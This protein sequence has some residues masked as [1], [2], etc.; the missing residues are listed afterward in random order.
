MS[1]FPPPW[2]Q[3]LGPLGPFLAGVGSILVALRTGVVQRLLALAQARQAN[4]ATEGARLDLNEKM[5]QRI[6]ALSEEVTRLRGEVRELKEFVRN[7][8]DSAPRLGVSVTERGVLYVE[9]GPVLL[10]VDDDATVCIYVKMALEEQNYTVCTATNVADALAA[11]G[12]QMPAVAIL[13]LYLGAETCLPIVEA[14][15]AAVTPRPTQIIL[16]TGAN[17]AAARA[18]V[19]QIDP[20]ALLVKGSDDI[21]RLQSTVKTALAK[22]EASAIA[23]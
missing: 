13:D 14:L 23:P 2:L 19:Q 12:V 6:E 5:M 10:A 11:V 1:D 7:V 17:D 18:L 15:R 9:P 3:A 20:M 8:H 21:M 16:Y 22:R 4:V